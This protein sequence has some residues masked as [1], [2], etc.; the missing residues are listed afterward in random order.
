[1][2]LVS[3]GSGPR[4]LGTIALLLLAVFAFCQPVRAAPLKSP[5]TILAPTATVGDAK[6]LALVIGNSTYRNVVTLK[7]T[8]NDASAVASKLRDLGFQVFFALDVDRL[9]LNE[10]IAGFLAH[11]EP[12]AETVVY[13]SGH[14]VEVQGSNYLLPIDI[15]ELGADEERLLRS[16]A[17]SLTD[18]L[19][20]L[21]SRR[22][23]VS[24][25]ILD[26]CRNNPFHISGLTRALGSERG[27][28]RVDP[29]RGTFVIFSAGAGETALDS[30]GLTDNTPNGLFTRVLLQL[31]T[32][33]GLEL[34]TLVRQLRGQV[35]EAAFA[36]GRRSQIPSYY[37][38]LL[39]DF[40]FRPK[41][42]P[43]PTQC[44]L[45]VHPDATMKEILAADGEAG[46]RACTQAIADDPSE[47]RYVHLL[48][49]AQEQRA[50]QKAL[51]TDEAAFSEAYLTLF[52][53]GRFIADVKS[54]L[55]ELS[56]REAARTAAKLEAEKLEAAK[57]ETARAEIAKADA[58][59]AAAQGEEA[60]AQ[61]AKAEAAK[62]AAQAE[63]A[64]AEA[65]R[66]E[67]A[68]AETAK[69]AAQAE[70]ARAEAAKAEAAK[71]AAQA[72]AA[73][74]EAARATAQAELAKA[75]AAKAE[76]AKAAA[77]TDAAK[78]NEPSAAVSAKA[79]D[80]ADIARLIQIHLKEVGCDPG[81]ANGDWNT[82]TRRALEAFNTH[83]GTRL[84]VT[85]A[86][87]DVLDAVRSKTGRVCPLV[88]GRGYRVEGE[89]CVQIACE[90]GFALDSN[91]T[92]QKRKDRPQTVQGPK[93]APKSTGKC[94]TFNGK[95]FCE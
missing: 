9:G 92:C 3:E 65:A 54:R 22:A 72:D 46:I 42:A 93:V 63:A 77:Q 69:A 28:A 15:P 23:R 20:D 71:V 84:D 81:S 66:A 60:R 37:D 5:V 58:A 52:P 50:L 68:K 21:E 16:E 27:L 30:L 2:R 39:G 12:N 1:M 55:V 34:R 85:T 41:V 91:G 80:T 6:R 35:R 48:Y 7:N 26:A 31:M 61:T 8:S 29:P 49:E 32:V 70:T 17:V 38:Q 95:Q 18:L 51:S 88:C 10:A 86:S 59:K 90:P 67:I 43:R 75:E 40:Y 87:L 19:F 4:L 45:L 13:Y 53:N 33:D 94:F 57:A 14:G 78:A 64:R 25:V 44:D 79:M 11:I 73:K 74:A 56:K 83:A 47:P 76:A 82:E 36:F 62:A 89:R 24:L